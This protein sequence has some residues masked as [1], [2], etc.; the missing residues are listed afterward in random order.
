MR[1]LILMIY[2]LIIFAGLYLALL[3]LFAQPA[4]AQNGIEVVDNRA[5]P[6]FPE[7]IEFNLATNSETTIERVTLNYG[8]NARN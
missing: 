6:R 8:T 5:S 4:A 7:S 3:V 1:G 2:K